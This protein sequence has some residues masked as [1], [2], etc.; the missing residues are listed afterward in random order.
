MSHSSVVTKNEHGE[1]VLT[2][3]VTGAYDVVRFANVM[4]HG[5]VEFGDSGRQAHARVQRIIGTRNWNRLHET[6]FGADHECG[7]RRCIGRRAQV[8]AGAS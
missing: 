2:V 5:Q 3:T 6:L 1:P 8:R 4:R 7:P